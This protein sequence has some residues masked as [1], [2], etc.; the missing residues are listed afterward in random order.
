M[1]ILYI[2]GGFVGAC[3]AAVSAASGH[4][5]LVFDIDT[6]K[7]KK[8]GAKDRNIIESCLFEKGLGDLLVQHSDRITFSSDYADLRCFWTPVTWY[9]CACQPQKLVKPEKAMCHT[10]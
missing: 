3:S 10:M 5:I 1:N 9:L 4:N 8:L 6:E 2:G 7:I